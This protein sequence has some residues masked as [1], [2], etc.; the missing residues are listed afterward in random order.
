MT[1]VTDSEPTK[2]EPTELV[3]K[4]SS[5]MR[6]RLPK[7][8]V[9]YTSASR[10]HGRH[11]AQGTQPQARAAGDVRMPSRARAALRKQRGV[12]E[13]TRALVESGARGDRRG[14]LVGALGHGGEP[15]EAARCNL[16]T[17]TRRLLRRGRRL[18]RRA[19]VVDAAAEAGRQRR[20]RR[21]NRAAELGRVGPRLGARKRRIP[22]PTCSRPATGPRGLRGGRVEAPLARRAG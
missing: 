16:R 1:K 11:G 8:F 12:S 4:E 2:L 15:R 18:G 6:I 5:R 21:R 3:I 7:L 10:R 20:R 14:L 9:L 19:R 22:C 17:R 13:K